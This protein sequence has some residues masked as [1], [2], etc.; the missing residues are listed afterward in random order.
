[1]SW[2]TSHPHVASVIAGAS[3]P[4]QARANAAAGQWQLSAD[5]RAE[6]DSIVNT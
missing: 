1:M 4:D 3:K 6:V 5:D 2:L